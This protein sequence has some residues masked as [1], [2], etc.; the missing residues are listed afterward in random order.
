MR[1]LKSTQAAVAERTG[2]Q[3]VSADAWWE[4]AD[5]GQRWDATTA[6]HL[7]RRAGFGMTR[8]GIDQLASMEMEQAVDALLSAEVGEF[9]DTSN[10]MQS[11]V[12]A[13]GELANISAW[14]LFVMRNSPVQLREKM[15]LFWHGHFATGADKVQS[16][17][18]MVRQNAILR[19]EA[20]ESFPEM[21][22]QVARDPA[23]LI[24]L[25]STDN[26]RT[27]PNE[28]WARELLELFCLGTGNY[29]EQDIKELARCFT[30]WEVHRQRFRFNGYQHDEGRKTIFGQGGNLGGDEAIQIVLEQPACSRFIAKKLFRFLVSDEAVEP[31]LLEPLAGH[32]RESEFDMGSVVRKILTS[33]Y[34]YSEHAVAR[35]IRSPIELAVGLMQCLGCSGNLYRL[36]DRLQQLGQRPFYPPN[37][38]GWDGGRKWINSSTLLG[39][40]NLVYDLIFGGETNWPAGDLVRWVGDRQASAESILGLCNQYLLAQPLAAAVQSE[41]V[42]QFEDERFGDHQSVGR[43]L[44]AVSLQP[45]FQLG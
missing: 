16:G 2:D 31:E 7:V 3:P 4:T 38:K 14:W 17:H 10:A 25:D 45:E 37:V 30:G 43:L 44:H 26:R 5:L 27:R 13:G 32:L 21:V 18:A 1:R 11:T 40:A 12:L 29:S 20:L 33:R 42:G 15:T 34:F 24:Y 39:R 28:N 23:M 22:R 9:A 35:K 41:L 36:A 8:E 6:S 19:S